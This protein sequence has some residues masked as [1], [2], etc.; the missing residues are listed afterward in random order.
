MLV[1]LTDRFLE[2]PI[3]T[4]SIQIDPAV[5]LYEDEWIVILCGSTFDA[6]SVMVFSATVLFGHVRARLS[7][8]FFFGQSCSHV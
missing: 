1:L 8:F 5:Q 3:T 7:F 6:T 2:L 4:R